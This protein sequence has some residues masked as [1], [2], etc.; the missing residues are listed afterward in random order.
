VGLGLGIVVPALIA[1]LLSFVGI[2]F[3]HGTALISIFI[4]YA[5]GIAAFAKEKAWE[6]IA[7]PKDPKLMITSVALALLLLL[8]FW[9]RMQTYSPVFMELDPYYYMYITHLIVVHGE[10]P[11][12]DQTAWYPLET[13]HRGS[14]LK[15]YAEAIQYSLYTGG[16]EYEKYL[17]SDLAGSF[18][19]VLAALAV[20]FLALFISAEYKREF[21][22]IAAAVFAFIPMFL[23]KTLA[24][25]SEIQ[26]YA[27]FALAF[28]FAMYALAIKR[29]DYT[30]A[31]LLGW[32]S[33][34]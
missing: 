10:V 29:K 28:F 27:F 7:L 1:F 22:L 32:R 25:E 4:F 24:G 13:S 20:F 16:G 8:S 14:I 33:L 18:P 3:S 26:P 31:G 12:T 15:P 9:I 23:T 5:I 30:F 11:L 19:A 17:M 21:G 2:L 6:Q 34:R